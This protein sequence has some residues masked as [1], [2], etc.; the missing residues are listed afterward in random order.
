MIRR[1]RFRR[2]ARKIVVS[3]AHRLAP[4]GTVVLGGAIVG[5]VLLLFDVV[6]GRTAGIAAAAV[7]LA[8]LVGLWAALP[9]SLRASD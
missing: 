7:T 2:H 3:A 4:S 1:I 6:R 9:W 8:L 5:V